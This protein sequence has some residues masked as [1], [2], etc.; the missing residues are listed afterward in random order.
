MTRLVRQRK[1]QWTAGIAGLIALLALITA[2]GLAPPLENAASSLFGPVQRAFRQAGEP[3]S[4]LIAE[5][6]DLGRLEGE[7]R[8]LRQRVAQLEAENARF[9]EEDIRR[10]GRLALLELIGASAG[11]L[12]PANVIT[13]DLTGLRTVIGI[14]RGADD[15]IAAGMP[16]VAAGGTLVG[17]VADVRA[18]TAFVRL[19]TDPDS[20][21]RVL[22]QVSRTEIVAAGDTLGNLAIE[23]PWT[24]GVEL[25]QMFVTSGL[26]GL[27]PYGLPVGR[28][29]A[30]G[31]TAEDP[32]QR[33]RLQPV[34]PL[35]QLEQVL[36]QTA[37]GGRAATEPPR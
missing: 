22:H 29:A 27:I 17:V 19:V 11:E 10:P 33:V 18:D 21:I 31:G 32:F 12:L 9:R 24:A 2:V 26:D 25:G 16:A 4:D 20:A 6:E 14:D 35:E 30:S 3:I 37:A 28:A 7:N 36:I 23:I 34:A 5:I 15:G 8:A 1:F 13:R